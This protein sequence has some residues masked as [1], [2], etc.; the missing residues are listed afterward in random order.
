MKRFF[1]FLFGHDWI[2]TGTLTIYNDPDKLRPRSVMGSHTC[3]R[4]GREHDWQY[5]L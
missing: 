1:C 2:N 5:D 3:M 4:C